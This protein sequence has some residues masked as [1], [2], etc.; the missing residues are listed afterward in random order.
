M[1]PCQDPLSMG[2]LRQ[3]YWNGEPFPSPGNLPDPEIESAF[4]ELEGRFFTAEP[5]GKDSEQAV[6]RPYH[7]L[8][9]WRGFLKPG[10]GTV[11]QCP[12]GVEH[13][14]AC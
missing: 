14:T 13:C 8:H 4:P 3:E 1:D 7:Q 11:S 2:F 10:G 5:A 9:P 6:K 12:E